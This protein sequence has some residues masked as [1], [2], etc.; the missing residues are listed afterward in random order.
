MKHQAREV[1]GFV[2]AGRLRR[3]SWPLVA[4]VVLGVV[5]FVFF[6]VLTWPR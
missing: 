5:L 3:F 1:Y 4:R 2:P 6:V